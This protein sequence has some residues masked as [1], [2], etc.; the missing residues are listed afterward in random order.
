MI[1][2]TYK[3]F[4]VTRLIHGLK[5]IPTEF[6]QRFGTIGESWIYYTPETNKQSKQW[7][8]R[9]EPDPKKGEKCSIR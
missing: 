1:R 6:L 7:T 5:E 4:H 8:A 9:G 2:L 3:F